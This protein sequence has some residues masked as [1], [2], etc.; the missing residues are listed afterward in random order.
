MEVELV[1]N[2]NNLPLDARKIELQIKN[3]LSKLIFPYVFTVKSITVMSKWLVVLVDFPE[4]QKH[5][6]ETELIFDAVAGEIVRQLV[7]YAVRYRHFTV[8]GE[9]ESL[10]FKEKTQP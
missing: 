1:F 2:R 4:L 10:L 9:R 5:I 7:D 8:A 3:R 6:V